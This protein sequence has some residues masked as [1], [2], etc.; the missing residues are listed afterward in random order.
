MSNSLS[1]NGGAGEAEESDVQ[2]RI[3]ARGTQVLGGYPPREIH[4]GLARRV[5]HRHTSRPRRKRPIERILY[6]LPKLLLLQGLEASITH[7]RAALYDPLL[8][9][10][11]CPVDAALHDAET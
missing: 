3:M 7:R 10:S 11:E 8:E 4:G 5:R 9:P 2:R 1:K 6:A